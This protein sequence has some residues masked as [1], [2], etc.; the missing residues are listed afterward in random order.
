MRDADHDGQE[1]KHFHDAGHCW[2]PL[3]WRWHWSL[4]W[5][6]QSGAVTSAAGEVCYR[7]QS[8]LTGELWWVE[9]GGRLI[10][11]PQTDTS[12]YFLWQREFLEHGKWNFKN[13]NK[14]KPSHSFH[15]PPPVVKS[16]IIPPQIL[17]VKLHFDIIFQNKSVQTV[18]LVVGKSACVCSILT[19]EQIFLDVLFILIQWTTKI[20]T[21]SPSYLFEKKKI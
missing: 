17:D 20:Q 4:W 10:Y 9:A 15:S 3:W 2:F 7:E 19:D 13:H 11:P 8:W 6:W 14:K 18:V 12:S 5:R 16:L 21:N 1:Q